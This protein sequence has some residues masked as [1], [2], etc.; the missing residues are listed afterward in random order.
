MSLKPTNSVETA[1]YKTKA[2]EVWTQIISDLEYAMQNLPESY[3]V[4]EYAR[5]TK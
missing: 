1:V 5:V 3:S 4:S 2:D